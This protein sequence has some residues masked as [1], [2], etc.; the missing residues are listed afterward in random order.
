MRQ[1]TSAYLSI[2]QHACAYV[3]RRP[4]RQKD[5]RSSSSI[6]QHTIRQHT[7]AYVYR[8]PARQKDERSSCCIRQHTSAYVSI[9]IQETSAP[10]GRALLFSRA[11]TGWA[12]QHLCTTRQHTSA[13][14]SIRQ[15]TSAYVSISAAYVS[16][17]QRT[18]AYVSIRQQTS[19]YARST[20]PA[21]ILVGH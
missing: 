10:E 19:A 14:V 11:L 13:Y 2:P 9:R 18:S 7:S 5:E 8:R 17:R 20:L 3:Y 21:P 12:C 6:R 4:A 1:H 15:H 16:V